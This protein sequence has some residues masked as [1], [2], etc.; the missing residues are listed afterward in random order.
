MVFFYCDGN[1][2]KCW[3]RFEHMQ[4]FTI[5]IFIVGGKQERVLLLWTKESL[6]ACG[7]VN[8][9]EALKIGKNSM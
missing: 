6:L 2:A 8:L 1:E 5:E 7:M 9:A 3:R 4:Y